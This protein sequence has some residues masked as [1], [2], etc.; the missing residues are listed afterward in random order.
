MSSSPPLGQLGGGVVSAFTN[1]AIRTKT[2]SAIAAMR[3]TQSVALVA[4]QV[5]LGAIGLGAP[6][7]LVGDVVGRA[8]GSSRL[9]RAAWRTHA[10]AFRRVSWAGIRTAARRY[11]QFPIF[12]SWSALLSAL[13]MQAPI[14]ALVA[15]YGTQV[16]GRYALAD[17]VGSVPLALVAG[18]VGQVFIAE[19]ARLARDQPAA[20]RS[21][22]GRTTRS[23]ARTA[24]GPA[25]VLA[26]SAPVLAGA[27]FGADW[28]EAG[29]FVAILA[30]MYYLTFVM[31]ATG[32]ILY[33]L[34]RQDLHLARE[35]L[36]FGFLGG[37]IPL[38]ALI[39]LP[40]I[41]AV[42]LLSAAGCVAY[43]LYGLISWRAVLA[44]P[45][46]PHHEA[47]AGPEAGWGRGGS[48]NP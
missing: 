8:S 14:L 13:A 2:F 44:F 7:L 11:R 40:A 12:S 46:H 38:A 33:V 26:V 25:A 35:V 24:I 15:L 43:V 9:G 16:G 23:L 36:R 19:S 10:Q 6:G 37:A 18:A 3:L 22:F 48:T 41:G 32:D 39:G 4:T 34:E 45:G 20:L 30:P 17:R 29:L 27:V 47:G 42:G 1:W 21:L 5:G 28:G 31:S